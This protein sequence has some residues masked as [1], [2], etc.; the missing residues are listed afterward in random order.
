MSLLLFDK[1]SLYWAE[2]TYMKLPNWPW[3]IIHFTIIA[4]DN[5][6]IKVIAFYI[7]SE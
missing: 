5:C 6:S 7:S 4:F 2:S 1:A 3:F